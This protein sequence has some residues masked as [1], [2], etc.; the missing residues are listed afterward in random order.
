LRGEGI[1]IVGSPV[2][3]LAPRVI[4]DLAGVELL[5]VAAK[6]ACVRVPPPRCRANVHHVVRVVREARVA[7]L[8]EQAASE[9]GH[10]VGRAS[11]ARADQRAPRGRVG[12]GDG[13]GPGV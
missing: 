10:E 8:E 7:T 9:E 3:S 13:G 5:L 12:G 1:G 2:R 11:A 6:L 4:R